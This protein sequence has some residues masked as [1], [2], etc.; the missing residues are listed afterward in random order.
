MGRSIVFSLIIGFIFGAGTVLLA[1]SFYH[2]VPTVVYQGEKLHIE[3]KEFGFTPTAQPP[4]LY[5]RMTGEFDFHALPLK[6]EGFVYAADIPGKLLR[7][8]K[9]QYYFAMETSSGTVTTLPQGAPYSQLYEVDVIPNNNKRPGGLKKIQINLLAP[10]ENETL[11]PDD[12][13]ISFSVPYSIED[14][15]TLKFRIIMDG[16][17]RSE[18]LIREGHVATYIPNSIRSG[19]HTVRFKVYNPDGILIGQR[20]VRFRISD[21]PSV[22]Q[23]FSYKGSFF[24]DNRVQQLNS[25][26]LNYTRGGL[27]LNFNYKKFELETRLLMTTNESKERQPLNIYSL[28]FKYNFSYRYFLYLWGGDV[29]PDY[30]PLALQGRRIRGGSIGLYTRFFNLDVTK[31]QSLRAIEGLPSV[32]PDSSSIPLRRGTYRQNF[33]S[34]HP[35]FNF[36]S[37]FSWGINLVNAKDDPNSI[38]Y[39]P[40]PKEYLV[41]GTTFDLNMHSRR[42]LIHGSAQASIKNEDASHSVDFD[43]LAN[44]LEL[45]GT[46]RKTAKRIV[47]I[48]TKPGFITVSP[49]LAPLPSLALQFDTQLNYFNQVLRFSYKHIDAE[50]AT[51]GNPYLLKDLQGFFV[52]DYLRLLNNRMFMNVFFNMYETN[53]SYGAAKTKN[54]D[55]GITFSLTPQ[56]NLPS[57]SLN[58]VNYDRKNSVLPTDSVLVAENNVTQSIGLSSSYNFNLGLIR[59][60]ISVS[61]NHFLR[62]DKFKISQNQYNLISVGLRNRFAIP[63]TSRFAYSTSATDFGAAPNKQ[64]TD[65]RRYSF[66]LEYLIRT[67]ILSSQLKPFVNGSIQKIKNSTLGNTYQ[68]QNYTLGIAWLTSNLGRLSVRYDYISYDFQ[69]MQRNDSILSTRYN[70][71][72]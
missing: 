9:V 36:G 59:N 41:L 35:Q 42:I 8:G 28:R 18:K 40:N 49:G 67:F 22:H 53:R 39:G 65:I 47:D 2:D 20:Q 15:N 43:T 69:N 16:I 10:Q 14:P 11:N 52:N 33:F 50:Y 64:S 44:T 51:P 24:V 71:Y 48:L 72:F 12:V 60:T 66:G 29:A 21:M 38:K 30:G 13:F 62:D 23:A 46:D 70:I 37:H 34:V 63:L 57:V 55:F 19:Y 7:P 54:K 61:A 32:N 56:S 45:E 4:L 26:N 27:R 31:G 25:T 17:D 1:G 3:L 6:N 58:Y 5:Y 68:R